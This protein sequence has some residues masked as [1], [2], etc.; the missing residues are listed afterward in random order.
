M[1][2]AQA[3]S[4]SGPASRDEAVDVDAT[5]AIESILRSWLA[6]P[7]VTLYCGDWATGGIMELLPRGR[8]RL[9]GPRYDGVFAGLREL[10]LD[11][12]AHHVH[13]D[14]GRLRHACYLVVPSVCY[15]FRPSFELRLAGA[16]DDPLQRYGLGLAMTQ[17]YARGRLRREP[18]RRYF[19]RVADHLQRHAGVASLR[20]AG[21]TPAVAAVDWAEI[22][23]L[24]AADPAF[25]TLRARLPSSLDAR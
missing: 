24:L 4:E 13:L 25:A 12:G 9:S 18:A 23:A 22:E 10:R 11:E 8:A 15:G 19:A 6:D 16:P 2:A 3:L 21:A 1:S 7:E 17:P 5:A 14:L 20:F